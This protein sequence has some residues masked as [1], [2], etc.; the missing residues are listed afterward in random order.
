[1]S[2][3]ISNAANNNT[4]YSRFHVSTCDIEVFSGDH[5]KWPSF[6]DLFTAIYINNTLLS[7]VEKLFHLNAKTSANRVSAILALAGESNWFHVDTHSNPADLATRGL[8]PSDLRS[9]NLWWN[10]P[11]WLFQPQS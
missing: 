10:G 2:S 9:N 7:K 1:M 6:R 5:L 4:E 8:L 11:D 3:H